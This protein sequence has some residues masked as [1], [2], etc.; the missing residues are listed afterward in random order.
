MRKRFVL[1][2]LGLAALAFAFGPN[3]ARAD[4]CRSGFGGGYGGYSGYGGYGGYRGV[5]VVPNYGISQ[6]YGYGYR[7]IG[8][9]YGGQRHIHRHHGYYG[10][11]GFYGN[12]GS[13]FYLRSPGFS[14]GIFR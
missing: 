8:S 5:S 10:N 4:H 6:S 13:S 12:R 1:A 11:R 14:F 9:Y 7:G 3:A 2:A